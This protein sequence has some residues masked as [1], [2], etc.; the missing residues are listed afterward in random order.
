M[1]NFRTI[2]RDDKNLAEILVMDKFSILHTEASLP[3]RD[4]TQLARVIVLVM[5]KF[6]NF[7]SD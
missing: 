2:S 5:K 3:S 1:E 4:E 6:S 7:W